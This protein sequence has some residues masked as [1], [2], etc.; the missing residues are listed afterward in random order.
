MPGYMFSDD[1]GS[2]SVYTATRL[3]GVTRDRWL[4]AFFI[5]L[6][7]MYPKSHNKEFK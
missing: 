4:S 5:Y 7:D 3:H 1:A 2:L 6:Y